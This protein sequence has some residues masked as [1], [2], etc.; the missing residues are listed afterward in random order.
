M[1]TDPNERPPFWRHRYYYMALKIGVLVVG[2]VV[3]LR[4]LGYW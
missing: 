1:T 4:L 3:A 2:I